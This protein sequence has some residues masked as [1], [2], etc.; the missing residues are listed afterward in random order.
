MCVCVCF[1][2]MCVSGPRKCVYKGHSMSQC[3][4]CVVRVIVCVCV[5]VCVFGET[6]VYACKRKSMGVCV[7]HVC[8]SGQHL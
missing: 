3:E 1:L 5:C 7:F 8:V 6:I 2:C 4:Y